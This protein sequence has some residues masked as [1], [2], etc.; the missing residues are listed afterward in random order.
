VNTFPR[1]EYLDKEQ[2]LE[3]LGLCPSTSLIVEE[4]YDEDSEDE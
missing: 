3:A 1:K 2:T 4:K